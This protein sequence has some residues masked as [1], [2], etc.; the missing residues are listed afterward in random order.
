M[1]QRIVIPGQQPPQILGDASQSLDTMLKWGEVLDDSHVLVQVAEEAAL[2]FSIP[3]LMGIGDRELGK[4]IMKEMMQY[5]ESS[6]R[7]AIYSTFTFDGVK[8]AFN[9]KNPTLSDLSLAVWRCFFVLAAQT[10]EFHSRRANEASTQGFQYGRPDFGRCWQYAFGLIPEIDLSPDFKQ[11]GG[12]VVGYGINSFNF[13]SHLSSVAPL[14]LGISCEL[15][16]LKLAIDAV[17]Y[18]GTDT[19]AM[20][21]G[22]HGLAVELGLSQTINLPVWHVCNLEETNLFYAEPKKFAAM[23]FEAQA[24]LGVTRRLESARLLDESLIFVGALTKP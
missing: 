7:P 17:D 3:T 8:K 21:R 1:I 5:I 9:A 10:S 14:G 19:F 11:L 2:V 15:S 13:E 24:Q 23:V 20:V 6:D 4:Q 16:E 22:Q 12:L 18:C